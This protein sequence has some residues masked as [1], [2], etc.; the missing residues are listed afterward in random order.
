MALVALAVLTFA[1]ALAPFFAG[2]FLPQHDAPGHMGLVAVQRMLRNGVPGALERYAFEPRLTP[3]FLYYVLVDLLGRAIGIERADR[4]FQVLF[5]G[6]MLPLS[7][8]TFAR[9]HGR[10][11]WLGLIVGS[12]FVWHW[13]QGYGFTQWSASI[14][15]VFFALS[16]RTWAHNRVKQHEFWNIELALLLPAIL[17]SAAT[18]S[19]HTFGYLVLGSAAMLLFAL[20][21]A[22]HT[23]T[24]PL[25]WLDLGLFAPGALMFAIWLAQ[26]PSTHKHL[27][28]LS[29]AEH[30]ASK[31]QPL[32]EAL[33]HIPRFGLMPTNAHLDAP[34]WVATLALAG[35]AAVSGQRRLSRGRTIEALAAA[36]WVGYFII[37]KSI[38]KPIDWWGISPRFVVLA[39]ITSCLAALRYDTR[40]GQ[41][42][43][44]ALTCA[45]IAFHVQLLKEFQQFNESTMQ[46]FDT[47]VKKLPRDQVV[48]PVLAS[49]DDTFVVTPVNHIGALLSVRRDAHIPFGM[50]HN[51]N[52]WA[53]WTKRLPNLRWGSGSA[54][55]PYML[56][57]YDYV[58][59]RSHP[60]A[61]VMG[62]PHIPKGFLALEATAGQWRLYR[63]TPTQ[64]K[65]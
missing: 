53:K 8:A 26:K 36:A 2:P 49:R 32:H 50:L 18:W 64:A 60:K 5:C 4:V 43:V 52:Y 21:S 48:L 13:G 44:A 10:S 25:W 56:Q 22:P 27:K 19:M 63:V 12:T 1:F 31:I 57:H 34:I 11:F 35:I 42:G 61:P 46:G 55:K 62:L 9:I 40:S 20:Q 16:F 30:A 39:A 38:L 14:P 17:F 65:Q 45:S 23:K 28:P 33:Q 41:I 59:T 37:P 15:L 7:V 6:V 58:I 29:L 3:N 54:V 47:V 24:R 51:N